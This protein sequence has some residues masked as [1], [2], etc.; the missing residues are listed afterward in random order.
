MANN[1]V[2]CLHLFGLCTLVL[3]SYHKVTKDDELSDSSD[4]VYSREGMGG[5]W[6]EKRM[7]GKVMV[8]IGPGKERQGT[9][10][11]EKVQECL[12]YNAF[13]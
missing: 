13:F 5:G 3:Y 8:E 6:K 9:F 7:A 12:N 11:L 10:A 2:P 4:E 1:K